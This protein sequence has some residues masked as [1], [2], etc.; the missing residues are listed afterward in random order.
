MIEFTFN[1]DKIIQIIYYLLKL[2]D[3]KLHKSVLLR[4]LYLADSE[5]F[6]ILNT[7][8]LNDSY[9]MQENQGYTPLNTYNFLENLKTNPNDYL[10]RV[11]SLIYTQNKNPGDGLLCETEEDILLNVTKDYQESKEHDSDWYR[12][13]SMDWYLNDTTNRIVPIEEILQKMGKSTEDIE[14][15]KEVCDRENYLNN[16]LK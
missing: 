13:W 1:E 4:L 14:D 16:L 6:K 3:N 8:L 12:N 5:S 9:V 10:I 11:N 2:N 7:T 15:I